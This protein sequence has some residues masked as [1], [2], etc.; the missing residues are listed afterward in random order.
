MAVILYRVSFDVDAYEKDRG[1]LSD[2]TYKKYKKPLYI[3]SFYRASFIRAY[4]GEKYVTVD[5]AEAI[6]W[7]SVDW[8]EINGMKP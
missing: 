8:S 7:T 1:D 2:E 4:Y 6:E 5:K 3:E